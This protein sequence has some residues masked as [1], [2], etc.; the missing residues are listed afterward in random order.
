M[1]RNL[2][3]LLALHHIEQEDLLRMQRFQPI[4]NEHI[5]AVIK[6]LSAQ[7]QRTEAVVSLLPEG[8]AIE[9]M[10]KQQRRYLES[11]G[12][13]VDEERIRARL[14]HGRIHQRAGIAPRWFFG[15][16]AHL[17]AILLDHVWQCLGDDPEEAR[18]T[19][20]SVAKLLAFDAQIAM[21]AFVTE[22][23]EELVRLNETLARTERELQSSLRRTTERARD[24][25]RRASIA[26]LVAGLAHEIGTPMTI[27]QGYAEML[28]SSVKDEAGRKRLVIIRQQIDRITKIMKELLNMARPGRV[29]HTQVQLGP[30]IQRALNLLEVK[31]GE[32]GIQ[33]RID[34]DPDARI[35]GD[36]G[37]LEQLFINL[38]MNAADAMTRDGTL[39]VEV[40]NEER[41]VA[42]R[43][44][45]TGSGIRT[46]LLPHIFEPFFTTKDASLGNG[47]GLPV[48]HGI[49]EG[50]GGSI[51]VRSKEGHGTTFHIHFPKDEGAGGAAQ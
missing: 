44:S 15:A 34:I 45:D 7:L 3:P 39:G 18:Q 21:E 8:A 31:L 37:Q 4:L 48:A 30:I 13:P 12:T 24:A 35:L 6:E 29:P 17:Q 41:G 40:E 23:E 10:Q 14:H 2:D 51:E 25:E 46:D 38:F 27:I 5:D 50:H 32:R 19:S 11:L 47:L 36:P 33:R 28:D 22:R 49:I 43:V 42:V 20:Q 1:D 26:T 9:Q 16:L